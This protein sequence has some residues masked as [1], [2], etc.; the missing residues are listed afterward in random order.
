MVEIRPVC[1][2]ATVHC[3]FAM[4][5][6]GQNNKDGGPYNHGPPCRGVS[7]GRKNERNKGKEGEKEEERKKKVCLLIINYF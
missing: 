7:A 1:A 3:N 4:F 2:L 5:S 6:L